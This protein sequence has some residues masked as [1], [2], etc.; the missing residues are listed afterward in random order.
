MRAVRVVLVVALWVGMWGDAS[1]ANLIS[2]VALGLLIVA[3]FDTWRHGRLVVRPIAA[4]RFAGY[5]AVKLVEA[6]L[7]VARTVIAPR[8]A[9]HTGIIAL[10]LRECSDA[11]ATVVADAISLTPGTLTLEVRRDPLT[12]YVHAIDLRDVE[13]VRADIRTLEVLAVRAFGSPEAVA[14]LAEDDSRAWETR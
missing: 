14:G 1:P 9:V 10:P 11:V 5:F 4:A 7:V 8:G 12:L 6:T 3:S 2:G 13:K